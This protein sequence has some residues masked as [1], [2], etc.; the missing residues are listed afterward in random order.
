MCIRPALPPSSMTENGWTTDEFG[1]R[2]S[3][4]GI[5]VCFEWQASILYCSQIVFFDFPGRIQANHFE[6]NTVL[7]QIIIISKSNSEFRIPDF[8]L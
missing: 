4:F 8:E 5:E 6:Y 7:S 1:M 2:N 3:E